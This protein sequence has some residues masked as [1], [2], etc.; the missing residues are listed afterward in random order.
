MILLLLFSIIFDK[1]LRYNSFRKKVNRVVNHSSSFL[2]SLD[3]CF[4]LLSWAESSNYIGYIY[5]IASDCLGV[6][7][8]RCKVIPE[9]YFFIPFNSICLCLKR[10]FFTI[11]TFKQTH[12]MFDLTVGCLYV[13]TMCMYGDRSLWYIHIYYIKLLFS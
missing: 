1:A 11:Q 10:G 9:T 7:N 3:C 2:F 8:T 12:F 5:V 4:M 6:Y 13:C